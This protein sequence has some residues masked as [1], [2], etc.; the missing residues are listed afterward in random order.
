MSVVDT[1]DSVVAWA[2]ENICSKIKLKLP[3]D[4]HVDGSYEYKLINPSCHAIYIPTKDRTAPADVPIPSLCVQLLE[5]N[6][7]RIGGVM[8]L[9]FCFSAWDPGEHGEDVLSPDGAGG[10]EWSG[11]ASFRRL[12]SGW[13]DVW[14]FADIA[15]REI[16]GADDIAGHSLDREKGIDYGPYLVQ[17]D[18]PSF[19]PYWFA[20]AE[21]T[22]TY[23]VNR[24]HP[25]D[26]YL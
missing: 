15:L 18:V 6:E 23:G 25:S 5:S 9:R 8:R 13:R 3:D 16:G 22:L 12:S 2:E 21:I 7:R 1:L 20:W 10:Y 17:D 24:N 14:N 26:D 11:E 19:Y 4:K